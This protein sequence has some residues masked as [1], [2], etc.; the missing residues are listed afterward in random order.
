MDKYRT[1]FRST[2]PNGTKVIILIASFAKI[3]R[4]FKTDGAAW[5]Q[6]NIP[7]RKYE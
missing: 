3:S 7:Y 2:A 6:T 1:G 5:P 4:G